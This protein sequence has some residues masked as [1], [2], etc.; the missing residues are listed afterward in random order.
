M[1]G[2]LGFSGA[3]SLILLLTLP[4]LLSAPGDTHRMTAGM[5]TISYSCAV[6]VPIVSGLSWDASGIPALAF[7]PVGLCNFLLVGFASTIR[8]GA[9]ATVPFQR[10]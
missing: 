10:N 3:A 2:A 6:V 1:V 8:M 5:F 9:G 4:P 7:I